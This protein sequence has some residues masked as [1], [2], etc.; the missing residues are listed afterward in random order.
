[1]RFTKSL[2]TARLTAALILLAAS[3]VLF[4]SCSIA[5]KKDLI[6]YAKKNYGACEFISEEHKGSGNDEYRTVYLRDKETGIEYK[7]TTNLS[8]ISIDGSVFGYTE[9]KHSDFEQ[10]YTSYVLE[11][12]DT[13][14][15]ALEREYGLVCDYPNIT[16]NNRVSAATAEK[17]VKKLS[18]IVSEY[19]TKGLCPYE[20]LV[21]AEGTVYV[22]VYDAKERKWSA[23]SEYE[24]IDYVHAHYDPDAVFCDSIGAFLEQ[25]LS[26]EEINKLVSDRD[27]SKAGKA[28]Y[29]KD[30]D[31]NLFIA[32]DL[33]D[34]G[35]SDG[36]I[37]FFRD[38]AYGMEEIK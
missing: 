29:F 16:F 27:G 8:D 31:G 30:K 9:G 26:Y 6:K 13:E 34:F 4:C 36:G 23:S 11:E 22:G 20:H 3:V 1:M 32:I 15:K 2:G 12:A 24:V 38:T 37:R 18:E 5:S 25:F 35:I 17:A 28:Y 14:I 10:K 33:K 21:Y 7:V 19:D